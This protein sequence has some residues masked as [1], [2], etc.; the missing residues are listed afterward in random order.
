MFPRLLDLTAYKHSLFLFGPRQVGKTHLI[1]QSLTPHLYINLLLQKEYLRYAK[2]AALLAKEVALL[3]K[4]KGTL[5]IVIDEIQRCPELLNEIHALMESQPSLRFVLT[6]SSARKL[7]RTG[8]NL[9]GGRA[10]TC[11]LFPLTYLEMGKDFILQDALRFGGLPKMVLEKEKSDKILLLQSYVETYLKEEIQQEA[12]TRNVPA[13]ARFL[14]LAA[15]ENGNLLNFNNLARE[16]GVHAKTI[17]EYFQIVE[18]TLLGF[19]LLPYTR[20]HREKLVLHPKFYFFDTGVVGALKNELSSDLVAGSS[21]YGDAF[22]HWCILEIKRLLSYRRIDAKISFFRT[23]DGAEVDLILEINKRVWAIEIKSSSKPSSADLRG[24]KSFIKDHSYKRA[25]CLC[26][27][28]RP[29]LLDKIEVLP[30]RDFMVE[31]GTTLK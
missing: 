4:K 30:W 7:K 29:Y 3:D 5:L 11:S 10:V 17:K 21:P 22:E 6:G 18:D 13:F 31:L 16:V 23:S 25:V 26:Q 24:L 14:E 27:T 20:S 28:P 15:F 2:D 19:F 8:V 9:L 12:L 1:K